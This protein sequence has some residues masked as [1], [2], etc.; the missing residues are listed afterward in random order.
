[1]KIARIAVAALGLAAF[2]AAPAFAGGCSSYGQTKAETP[3]P[4]S[5]VGS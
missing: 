4:S 3:P 2:A 1:M 5:T